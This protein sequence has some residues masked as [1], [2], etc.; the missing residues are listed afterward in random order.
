MKLYFFTAYVFFSGK[1]FQ[2]SQMFLSKTWS[3]P[4][5]RTWGC[6][7]KSAQYVRVL[8]YTR[9]ERLVRDKHSSLLGSFVSY[10]EDKW[11]EY[12]P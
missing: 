3:L 8:H 2:A 9:L 5:G 7:P 11:V 12:D 6:I 10:E 4:E 1:P